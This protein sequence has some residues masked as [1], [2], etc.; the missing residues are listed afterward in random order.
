MV[1]Q[2]R[3]LPNQYLSSLNSVVVLAYTMFSEVKLMLFFSLAV[4]FAYKLKK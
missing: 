2:S 1:N 3:T 4:A